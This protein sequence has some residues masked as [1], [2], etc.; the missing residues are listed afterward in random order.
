MRHSFLWC[1]AFVLAG[2]FAVAA[3]AQPGGDGA[4]TVAAVAEDLQ[5]GKPVTIVAFGDSITGVYYHTGGRRAWADMLRIA[6]EKTFPETQISMHNAG[7]SGNTTTQG[8]AR[9]ERDVLAK[10][11]D[12]V[13][14]MFGMNDVVRSPIEDFDANLR[15]ITR[16]CRAA[17]A[18][19]VLATPNSVYENPGRP[20]AR[21]AEYAERVRRVAT[22]EHVVLADCYAA[23][24]ALRADDAN[25]WRLLMSETIHPNMNGH[26]LFAEVMAETI[27]GK[28]V[29]LADVAPPRDSLRFTLARLRAG[30]PVT[31]VAPAPYDAIVPQLLKEHYPDASIE[32]VKWPM[33]GVSLSD[34]E[35]WAAGVRGRKPTC[36]VVAIPA[37]VGAE[38]DETFIRKSMWTIAQCA[39]FGKAEW[40]LVPILPAVA[41]EVPPEQKRFHETFAM[42]VLQGYDYEIVVRRQGDRRSAAEILGEW[43]DRLDK[44]DGD[45]P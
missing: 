30:E 12:L 18:A 43:I 13:V 16:R 14:V 26:K 4:R 23:Y 11:P 21:L 7:I 37:S 15:E 41:A 35:Q 20:M 10:R 24:E 40:D 17:G 2:V 25:A 27:T 19:V 39:A 9:I 1:A 8:L 33:E 36:V 44:L 45:R 38:D 22:E 29:S 42:A 28:P 34:C 3:M 5:A 6:L 32:I 31:I